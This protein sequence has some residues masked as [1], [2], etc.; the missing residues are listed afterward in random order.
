ML[1]GFLKVRS[2][3]GQDTRVLLES[4]LLLMDCTNV[5]QGILI[6]VTTTLCLSKQ[7]VRFIP[8]GLHEAKLIHMHQRHGAK[9]VH[10]R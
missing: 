5:L 2:F 10:K 9:L 1:I 4:N 6:R 7:E 8:D 3:F